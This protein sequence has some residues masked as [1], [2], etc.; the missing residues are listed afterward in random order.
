MADELKNV[1]KNIAFI[2][3]LVGG[4]F[5]VLG[6]GYMFSGLITEGV[7][8]L[9]VWLLIIAF[10][11]VMVS[12]LAYCLIGLCMMPFLIVAQVAVPIWSAFTI[13]NKLEEAFPEGNDQT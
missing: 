1:D 9:I 10:A 13:K 11:W 4:L 6:L 7:V 2:L 12:I 8:R 5:G 3:E